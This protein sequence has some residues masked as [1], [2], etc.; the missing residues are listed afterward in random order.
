MYQFYTNK[1]TLN[2][3]LW[4]YYILTK[5]EIFL[6]CDSMVKKSKKSPGLK[7]PEEIKIIKYFFYCKMSKKL[8]ISLN[9]IEVTNYSMFVASILRRSIYFSMYY[10]RIFISFIEYC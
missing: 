9:K 7:A 10:K 2:L 3:G 5:T 8:F 4:L 1:I 6:K